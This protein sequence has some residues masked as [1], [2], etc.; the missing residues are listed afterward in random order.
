M[1][2]LSQHVTEALTVSDILAHTHK[3]LQPSDI[4]TF[5]HI[6]TA[7]GFHVSHDGDYTIVHDD[8]EVI[9][10]IDTDALEVTTNMSKKDFF[11]VALHKKRGLL[12]R[13]YKRT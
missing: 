8:S 2:S 6:A 7:E 11:D 3:G 12:T 1:K 13:L 10:R 4:S 5:L 9:A